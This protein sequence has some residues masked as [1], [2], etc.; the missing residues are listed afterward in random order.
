MS[1]FGE[2]LNIPGMR[3]G[4]IQ[5]PG[6]GPRLPLKEGD[7][8]TI[9]L[10]KDVHEQIVTE[11]TEWDPR[12]PG[13]VTFNARPATPEDGPRNRKLIR[14]MRW[15]QRRAATRRLLGWRPR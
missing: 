9:L 12:H 8:V 14:R 5:T 10:G 13:D 7:R 15:G 6:L 11:V 4:T 1:G 3:H 2:H